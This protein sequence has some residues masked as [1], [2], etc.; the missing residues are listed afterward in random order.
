M[1]QWWNDAATRDVTSKCRSGVYVGRMEKI[2]QVMMLIR[3]ASWLYSTKKSIKGRGWIPKIIVHEQVFIKSKAQNLGI[4]SLWKRRII[5][6]VKTIQLIFS[7]V[8]HHYKSHFTPQRF[9]PNMKFPQRYLGCVSYFNATQIKSMTTS[10]ITNPS[11]L[12]RVWHIL[13]PFLIDWYTLRG[14]IA[15][16]LRHASYYLLPSWPGWYIPQNCI[17]DASIIMAFFWC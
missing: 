17:A 7:F 12:L 4:A 15:R 1:V 2:R 14:C 3:L 5:D 11:P 8:Y 6:N 16:P 13:L 10:R 9:S